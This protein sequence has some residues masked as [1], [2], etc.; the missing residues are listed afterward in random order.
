MKLIDIVKHNDETYSFDFHSDDIKAWSEEDNSKL[1]VDIKGQ[2]LGKKF[3]Y[4]TFQM[5]LS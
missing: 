4:A 5:N 2:E 1:Y 3:S